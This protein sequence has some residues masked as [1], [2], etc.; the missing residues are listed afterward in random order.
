M[1]LSYW[2]QNPQIKEAEWK[3]WLIFYYKIETRKIGCFHWNRY[4]VLFV[5]CTE[6]IIE[7][8]LLTL[9]LQ[10]WLWS[11]TKMNYFVAHT[12]LL[13]N[14][15][16]FLTVSGNVVQFPIFSHY[17]LIWYTQTCITSPGLNLKLWTYI[18][19]YTTYNYFNVSQNIQFQQVQCWTDRRWGGYCEGLK[20]GLELH[21]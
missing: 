8:K 11:E 3:N 10:W 7:D 13:V 16:L 15:I 2:T 12:N 1:W 4:L 17:I 14:T 9:S 21:I 5:V 18:Q 19:L 6:N 20:T